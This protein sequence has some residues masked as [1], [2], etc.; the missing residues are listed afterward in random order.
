MTTTAGSKV[1]G[2]QA[3]A[4]TVLRDYILSESRRQ[5]ERQEWH[6]LLKRQSLP[7]MIYLLQQGHTSY[8]IPN[9]FTSWGSNIQT[10]KPMGAILI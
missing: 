4:G 10:Y 6:G 1:A 2:R 5:R 9:I 3:C 8:S 7:S